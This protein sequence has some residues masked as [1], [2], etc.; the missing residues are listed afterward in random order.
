[1][2]KTYGCHQ[3]DVEKFEIEEI[4]EGEEPCKEKRKGYGLGHGCIAHI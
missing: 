4:Y 1:M 2:D 3:P